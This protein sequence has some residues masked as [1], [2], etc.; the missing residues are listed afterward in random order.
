MSPYKH[1]LIFE[2]DSKHWWSRLLKRGIR[3]CHIIKPS[4]GRFI[5]FGRST[6][7]ADLFNVEDI[8]DIIGS[9][10]CIIGYNGKPKKTGLFMLNTCVGHCKQILGI[11]NPFILTPYQLMKYVRRSNEKTKAT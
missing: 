7:G 6:Q 3:H 2:D 10:F 4:N 1:Y 11:T 9:D 5:V 8:N